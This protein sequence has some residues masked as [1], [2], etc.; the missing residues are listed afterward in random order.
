M[1]KLDKLITFAYLR[2]EVDIPQN[3]QA[4][5]FDHKIY[6]AQETLRMLIGEGFYQ[7]FLS[8]YKDK[9]LSDNEKLFYEY[10]KQYVA[11]QAYEFWT[12]TANFK[13]T[14]SGFRVH[15]EENSV[16]ATDVQMATIIKDA[17]QSSQYYKKLMID[18]LNK[19]AATFPLYQNGCRNDL[20]GNT[21][22]I[23]AVKKK[24]HHNCHCH[25]CR[26]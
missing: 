23:S 18:Y 24:H 1:A 2:G 4:E 22:R 9:S 15:T 12:A 19:N 21:F 20:A 13:P 26:I 14:R 3:I 17:K 16:V 25:R 6:K 11:W 8:K 10:V 5:E 7:D